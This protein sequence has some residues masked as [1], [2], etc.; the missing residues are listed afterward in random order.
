MAASK[1]REIIEAIVARLEAITTAGGFNTDAG[2]L[3]FLNEAPAL[4]EDDPDEAIAVMV[5]EDEV[6]FQGEHMMINL[7]IDVQA[8][9]KASIDD[10]YL[11][12]E[13]VLQDVKTAMELADRTLGGLVKRQFLRRS[14]RTL[15]REPGSTYV[16]VV[17]TYVVPY[18][19]QW[20]RP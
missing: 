2:A 3:V 1:R 6:G 8:I 13:A 11:A 5:G 16:G 20:G 7:P 15:E 18:T 10:P 14:T 17:I 12:A 4:G 9:A 19:E